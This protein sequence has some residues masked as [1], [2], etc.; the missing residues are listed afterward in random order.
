[1]NSNQVLGYLARYDK[2]FLGG[3]KKVIWAPEFPLWLEQP[4]F[5]D[6]AC[7]LDYK[8]GP[9]FTL[10]LLDEQ[11]REVSLRCRERHWQP[12]HATNLY[13]NQRYGLNVAERRALLPWDTLVSTLEFNQTLEKE[14]T[15]HLVLWSA[16]E[17]FESNGVYELENYRVREEDGTL[18]WQ[19]RIR[20]RIQPFDP[21]QPDNIMMRF[22]VALGSNLK[23]ASYGLVTSDRQPNY[24][25]WQYTPFYEKI[26][27]YGH[28]GNPALVKVEPEFGGLTYFGLHYKITIPPG[29]RVHFNAF[30][31]IGGSEEASLVGLQQARALG[32]GTKDK[33]KDP[34]RGE[35]RASY[36]AKKEWLDYFSA[37]PNF[38]CSD[39]YLEKYYWY[40][41]YGLRLNTIRADDSR[42]G[43]PYPCI[44]EGINLGWFRQHITYSAQCHMLETRW[45]HDPQLAQGSLL[46]FI[47]NQQEDGS[48]PGVIKNIYQGDRSLRI[49]VAFYH[50]NWGM[51]VRELHR[52]HPDRAFLEKIYEP[53]C[54]YALY[55][56]KVRDPDQTGLYDVINHWE[57]GM[58]YMSRYQEVEANADQSAGFRLK[59]LDATVYIYQLLETLAWIAQTLAKPDAGRWQAMAEKTRR[60]V[61]DYMWDGQSQFFYDVNPATMQRIKAKAAPGFY[62]FLASKLAGSE[63]L[64]VFSQHLFNENEFWTTYPVPATS[65]DDATFSA[66]GEWNSQ[67]LVC[68]WNGRSWLMTNSHVTEALCRAALNISPDLRPKAV[69]LINRYIK[70][71]FIE[72]DI[73]RPSS[74]EYYNPL[75]GQAPFFRGTEDYMHSWIV[76]LI[77]KY[78][79]GVQPEDNGRVRIQPLPFNLDYF[80]LDKVRISGHELKVNWRKGTNIV[81]PGWSDQP[82]VGLTV[83]VD[84]Q[85]TVQTTTP[86][87]TEILL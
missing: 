86:G 38:Q 1:M 2:W 23:A 51:A 74:Y 69:E 87:P 11:Y 36:P 46:N 15:F 12:D 59:G 53:L 29:G 27:Q 84:G 40:R 42:I 65:R 52:V 47:V 62:P 6:H 22:H 18:L 48:F 63:Q 41:W 70:M 32:T 44:F 9:L 37:V 35:R 73:E 33:E 20:E 4:G 79:A 77:I 21:A 7:Y 64:G 67:R 16:Q 76:D 13:R 49:G 57:T 71:L 30:A 81:Q 80:T 82:P 45:M 26:A 39:P 66:E 34:N 75:T 19:R 72:G 24:P 85:Q 25:R 83:W 58:E 61:Q 54:R 28:L 68:P 55:F 78:V 31:S 17:R 56:D 43:L 60:A 8:V 3:G 50:A 5:W 10:T 14:Q